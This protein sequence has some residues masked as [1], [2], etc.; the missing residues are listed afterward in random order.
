MTALQN[1]MVARCMNHYNFG[2]RA[3]PYIRY[4]EL[5]VNQASPMVPGWGGENESGVPNLYDLGPLAHG[6]LLGEIETGSP[7]PPSLPAAEAREIDADY[8]RCQ[9]AAT[10]SFRKLNETG[11]SLGICGDGRSSRSSPLRRSRSPR[12]NSADALRVMV[13]Q[14]RQRSLPTHSPGGCP[15]WFSHP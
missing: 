6:G 15:I 12:V 7:N 11:F 4:D 13:R 2:P 1:L 8:Q 14:S 3:Q 9:I 10:Q 5:Y